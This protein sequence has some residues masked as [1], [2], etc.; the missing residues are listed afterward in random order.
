MCCVGHCDKGAALFFTL[1]VTR[2][3]RMNF[4][5][6]KKIGDSNFQTNGMNYYK[7]SCR[8]G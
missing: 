7:K 8:K 1:F 3:S 2:H 5:L 6:L 4:C